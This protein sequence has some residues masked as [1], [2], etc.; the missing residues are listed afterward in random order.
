VLLSLGNTTGGE[1]WRFSRDNVKALLAVLSSK[2]LIDYY[3]LIGSI[4]IGG[5]VLASKFISLQNLFGAGADSTI[6]VLEW[7]MAE[8]L[9]DKPAM[10]RLQHELRHANTASQTDSLTT[11]HD[12]QG[13]VYLKAV[14]N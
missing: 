1:D 12:L 11:E 5:P 2:I 8:L 7:A 14:I 6:I 4:R 9:R 3:V 10:E 13:M